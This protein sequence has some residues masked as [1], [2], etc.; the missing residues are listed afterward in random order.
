MSRRELNT[1]GDDTARGHRRRR[2][3]RIRSRN[4]RST[5]SPSSSPD[6]SPSR[7]N[8]P[9]RHECLRD[10]L[11]GW[12]LTGD[13][14]SSLMGWDGSQRCVPGAAEPPL[15]APLRRWKGD[16]RAGR[17]RTRRVRPRVVGT[18]AWTEAQRRVMPLT[19]MHARWQRVASLRTDGSERRQL[20]VGGVDDKGRVGDASRAS[21]T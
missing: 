13:Q 1:D 11:L 2:R 21:P 7:R 17:L 6:Q 16:A 12:A 19:G 4:W 3:S 8:R 9:R 20:D 18:T 10:A 15:S 14:R 5:A